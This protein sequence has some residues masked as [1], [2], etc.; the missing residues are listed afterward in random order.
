MQPLAHMG[1]ICWRMYGRYLVRSRSAFMGRF[2]EREDDE[3]ARRSAS[4]LRGHFR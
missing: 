4:A 1:V 3:A 2:L